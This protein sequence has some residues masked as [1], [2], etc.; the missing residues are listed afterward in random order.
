MAARFSAISSRNAALHLEE[1]SDEETHDSA[2]DDRRERARPVGDG[3][4]N[5][6]VINS[7]TVIREI[8]L[9]LDQLSE[10]TI[11]LNY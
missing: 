2:F 10:I 3:N 11:A 7:F 6:P 1:R 8:N 4:G 5:L 9:L